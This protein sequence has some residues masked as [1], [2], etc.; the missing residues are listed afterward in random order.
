M[1]AISRALS[2]IRF[3]IGAMTKNPILYLGFIVKVV[4]EGL[5]KPIWVTLKLILFPTTKIWQLWWPPT[6]YLHFSLGDGNPDCAQSWDG[7]D[8]TFRKSEL[9]RHWQVILKYTFLTFP[10]SEAPFLPAH[11]TKLFEHTR[12]C[13]VP[14]SRPNLWL[15]K[16]TNGSI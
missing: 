14:F 13:C 15:K 9:K 3:L 11:T 1:P 8:L 4:A 7:S 5:S 2:E 6:L 12:E 10:D 16:I